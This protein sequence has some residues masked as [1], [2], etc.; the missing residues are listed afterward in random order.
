MRQLSFWGK[1]A[2]LM[3]L[4]DELIGEQNE[5]EL[6]WDFYDMQPG[7][8]YAVMFR[9]TVCH[10]PRQGSQVNE[11]KVGPNDENRPGAIVG[12]VHCVACDQRF[13]LRVR[14]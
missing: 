7:K 3:A 14:A 1:T 11:L 8:S 10:F 9:C 6:P 2:E 13:R 5:V 12:R 4:V